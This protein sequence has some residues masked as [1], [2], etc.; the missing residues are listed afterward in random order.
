MSLNLRRSLPAALLATCATAAIAVAGCGGGDDTSST[1][2]GA[3]G[4][5]GVSG[6]A[7][8]Q[9]DFVS[10][11]NSIC[12]DAN[13]QIEAL[14]ALSSTD[15]ASLGDYAQQVLDIGQPLAAQ[16]QELVPPE[17]LQNQ[18]DD[19]VAGVQKGLDL[20]SQLVDAAKAGDTQE[21]NS[22]IQQIKA[23]D[24]DDEAKALGLTECAKDPQ[25]QG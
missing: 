7:L 23:N 12:A 9:D 24:N 15:L 16:L 2:A 8:S 1:T 3:S 19:Y 14:G 10:Q 21:A 25:P 5:S 6:T 18:F 17:D 11:G 13:S 20:D 22:L 4:A